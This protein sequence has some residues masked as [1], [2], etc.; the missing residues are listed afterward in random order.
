MQHSVLV[1]RSGPHI[2][3]ALSLEAYHPYHSSLWILSEN[4]GRTESAHAEHHRNKIELGIA[5]TH[6][7]HGENAFTL[8]ASY[9]YRF[10]DFASIGVLGE[11]A[12]DPLDQWIVGLP[13]KFYPGF[14]PA[15]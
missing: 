12:F 5:N 14:I 8:A 2:R 10:S 13:L 7:E 9:N 3:R 6:T 4:A 11:Y 15:A 1:K